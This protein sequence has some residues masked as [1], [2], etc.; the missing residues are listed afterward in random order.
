[1]LTLVGC[2][3]CYQSRQRSI[4]RLRGYE[5]WRQGLESRGQIEAIR[6]GP[7]SRAIRAHFARTSRPIH[8]QFAARVPGA[9]ADHVTLPGCAES[10][11]TSVEVGSQDAKT[12][13]WGQSREF[14]LNVG[15][16]NPTASKALVGI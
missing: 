10:D 9:A 1:M 8:G 4:P 11:G 5:L 6:T 13:C 16:N 12:D 15:D 14:L 7:G 3:D 2:L